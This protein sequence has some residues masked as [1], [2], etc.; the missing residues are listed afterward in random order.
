MT[1]IDQVCGLAWLGAIARDIKKYTVYTW[2]MLPCGGHWDKAVKVELW[3]S[4]SAVK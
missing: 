4:E 2:H 1:W 3:V